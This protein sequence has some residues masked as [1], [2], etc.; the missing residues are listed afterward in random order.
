MKERKKKK[1]EIIAHHS[2][3][4]RRLQ[5]VFLFI[6][7][8]VMLYPR[9]LLFTEFFSESQVTYR[10]PDSC[11][12]VRR[13]EFIAHH[14]MTLPFPDPLLAYPEGATPIWSPLYDW[15]SALPSFILGWGQPSAWLVMISAGFV[16]VIFGMGELLLIGIFMYRILRNAGIAIFS[17][18][19]AGISN[20][21]ICYTSLE[22]IDHNSLLGML[23][24]WSFLQLY[25]FL[26]MERDKKPW[27]VTGLTALMI[28]LFFWTWPGAYIHVFIIGAMLFFAIVASR[29]FHLFFPAFYTF[30]LASV[31]VLPLA[32]LNNRFSIN[33]LS[34][35]HVSF[36]AVL[37]LVLI[38]SCFCLLH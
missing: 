30:G 32:F 19:L 9:I 24:A 37:F 17:A 26:T 35:Q 36:L 10:S 11:Y 31:L 23:L 28:A 20:Y 27:K 25:N 16:S 12:H 8:A 4:N 21:Q 34:Y 14:N 38:A 33:M 3:W 22:S 18:F 13:I 7:V 5:V 1:T 29:K 15:I 2:L 6:A